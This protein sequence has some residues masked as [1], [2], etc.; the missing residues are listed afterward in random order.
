[1]FLVVEHCVEIPEQIPFLMTKFLIL[2]RL[3]RGCPCRSTSADR[4]PNRAIYVRLSK[5]VCSPP[6]DFLELRDLSLAQGSR[7]IRLFVDSNHNATLTYCKKSTLLSVCVCVG[8][9]MLFHLI[10]YISVVLDPQVWP[11]EM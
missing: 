2:L 3:I 5:E 7:F 10:Q 11:L 6:I 9:N 4:H 1:M 8:S